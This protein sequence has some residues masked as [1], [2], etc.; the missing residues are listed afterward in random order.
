MAAEQRE[1]RTASADLVAGEGIG[2]FDRTAPADLVAGEGMGA[3]DQL[4]VEQ[5]AMRNAPPADL[6][7]GEGVG[8]FDRTAPADLVAGEGIGAFDQLAVEQREMRNAPPAD[9]VAGEGV[10]AF[11]QL[12]AEQREMRNAPLADLSPEDIAQL[13]ELQVRETPSSE[14]TEAEIARTDAEIAKTEAE[15]AQR[16]NLEKTTSSL[17]ESIARSQMEGMSQYESSR[18][19]LIM[20]AIA[21]CVFGVMVLPLLQNNLQ[22]DS[23]HPV[24][25]DSSSGTKAGPGNRAASS[26]SDTKAGPTGSSSAGTKVGPSNQ[27]VAAGSTQSPRTSEGSSTASTEAPFVL[28]AGQTGTVHSSGS[29][30]SA[31][32]YRGPRQPPAPLAFAYQKL[33]LTRAIARARNLGIDTSQ[34]SEVLKSIEHDSH[35]SHHQGE[36]A[37]KMAALSKE[38]NYQLEAREPPKIE[39]SYVG[40]GIGLPAEMPPEGA[41]RE[42]YMSTKISSNTPLVVK[43]LQDSIVKSGVSLRKGDRIIS[44]DG[45][46]VDG[47]SVYQIQDR[48]SGKTGSEV[49]IQYQSAEDNTIDTISLPRNNKSSPE[50]K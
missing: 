32:T 7:A 47:L 1:R 2:A 24:Q 26:S 3:F 19:T 30:Y 16:K 42:V 28:P 14:Q 45:V 17:K 36:L 39:K 23:S 13:K 15:I 46:N 12:A 31:S 50:F 21:V 44:I 40:M 6:S 25:A 9:L 5:R 27:S 34:Y 10:G 4:A 33:L 35:A 49:K 20:V 29:S 43:G 37:A 48:L 11:D 22:A 8:A 38:L 41:D 18:K